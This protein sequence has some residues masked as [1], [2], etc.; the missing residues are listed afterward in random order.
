MSKAKAEHD[1]YSNGE[2]IQRGRG[3]YTEI[4]NFINLSFSNTEDSN[5]SNKT[6]TN[7]TLDISRQSNEK[8]WHNNPKFKAQGVNIM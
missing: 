8:L 2:N 6:V 3:R 1:R 7:I 4:I 5:T